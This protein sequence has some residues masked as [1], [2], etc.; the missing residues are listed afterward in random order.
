MELNSGIVTLK[1]RRVESNIEAEGRKLKQ[2]AGNRKQEACSVT[3]QS[4]SDM[5]STCRSVRSCG[6]YIFT[7]I[8]R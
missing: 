5:H 3:S 1:T 8:F 2:E 4:E 7:T 6:F